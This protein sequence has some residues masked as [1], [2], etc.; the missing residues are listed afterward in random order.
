MCRPWRLGRGF[1]LTGVTAQLVELYVVQAIASKNV[2]SVL[3]GVTAHCRA[4]GCVDHGATGDAGS[5]LTGVRDA[6]VPF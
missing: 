1:V 2:G 5:L 4:V 6:Q 3:T